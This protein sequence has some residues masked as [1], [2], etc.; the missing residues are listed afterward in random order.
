[1]TLILS[2]LRR[3]W[4]ELGLLAALLLA[5]WLGVGPVRLAAV[6]LA[7]GVLLFGIR[8]RRWAELGLLAALLLAT[9]LP[10]AI[11]G[12]GTRAFLL[13][14]AAVVLAGGVLTFAI[15]RR[16]WDVVRAG[17]VLVV[18]LAGTVIA[19]L[20]VDLGPWLRDMAEREA[21][22]QIER[23]LH[24]E[25]LG[26]H[27]ASGGF[28]VENLRIDGKNPG[29]RPFFT[30]KQIFVDLPWW[31][32]IRSRRLLLE[33]I[34]MSGWDMLVEKRGDWNNFI[35]VPRGPKRKPGEKGPF[36]TVLT[37]VHA[38]RGNFTYID[39]GS[40]TTTAANLDIVVDHS[41][42]R[43]LGRGSASAGRVQVKTYLP[44]RMDVRFTFE[45]KG[46]NVDFDRIELHTD[47]SHSVLTGRVEL[48]RWPE[49]TYQVRSRVDL[50]RSR[51]VFFAAEKWRSR[52]E[53]AFAGTYHLPQ[54][55]DF[56]LKGE[57]KA[58]MAWVNQ[59]AFP[60]LRGTIVWRPRSLD[61]LEATSR[62]CDGKT[63]FRYRLAPISTP[64][65]SIARFDARYEG[66][67]LA[68]FGDVLALKGIRMEGRAAGRNVM[69]WPLGGWAK[70][71]GEGEVNVTPPPGVVLLG[72]EPADAEQAIHEESRPYGPE[73][74]LA[75][76]PRP[77]PMGGRFV[78]RLEPDW[79]RVG[80][81][82]LSTERTHVSFEG[83][84]AYGQRSR[85]P[86]HARSA[87]WQESDRLLAS[88]ITAFG[89][90]TGV[91][92]V[93]GHG[94][95]SGVML[96]SVRSPRVEGRFDGSA[97]RAWD[98]VWG[99]GRGDIVVEN[100][101]V[102]VTGGRITEGESEI[103]AE[104]R[105][106]LGYPRR[107]GGEEIDAR[108]SIKNRELHDLRHAFELDDYPIEGKVSGEFH[109][110]G[111]YV[112]PYGYGRMTIADG[113]AWDE[114]F[115]SATA[116]LR[117]DGTGVHLGPA[118]MRKS[119]G[120]V[121]GA[122]HV[123][124]EGRYLFDADGR[125]IP[126]E[127]VALMKYESA[128]LSGVL[129]FKASGNGTF[130]SPRYEVTGRI[131]DLFV[132]DEGIGQVNGLLNVRERMLTLKV[133]ASSPRLT[134]TGVGSVEIND[135]MDADLTFR[136]SGTSLDPYLRVFE[137]RLSPFTRAVAGGTVR[138]VGQLYNPERL[139]AEARVED[140]DLTLFDYKLR[141]AG[142]IRIAFD[143]NTVLIDPKETLRLEGEDTKLEVTGILDDQ[144]HAID[145]AQDRIAVK[146]TGDSNLAVLQGFF[147]DINSSGRAELAGTIQGSIAKPVFSGSATITDGRLRYAGMPHSIQAIN[148]RIGFSADGITME[149]VTAQVANGQVR[150]GGGI[151]LSGYAPDRLTLTASGQNM[152]LRYPEGMRSLVDADLDL[153]GTFAAPTLRGT[154][155]VKDAVWR[156]RIEISPGLI[157][158]AS[159]LSLGGVPSA[160]PAGSLP[161]RFD[162]QVVAR[163]AL[164]I[165]NN[166]VQ[167]VASGDLGVRGDYER[168]VILGSV[169][170]ERGEVLLEGKRYLVT[171]GRV[172]FLNPTRIEPIIDI[173]AETRVRAPGQTYTVDLRLN[174]TMKR[175]D[176]Q[177]S[178]EPPLPTVEILT[179]LFGGE[180]ANTQD[181]E[182]RDLQRTQLQG[183]LGVSRLE[184]ALVGAF[185]GN[186]T[187]AVEQ[188]FRLDTVQLTPS[189]FDPYKS[190]DPTAR[191]TVGK[192]ISNRVYLTLAR[193]LNRADQLVLLEFDQ[194]DRLS[195]VFSR[196]EDDTYALDVRVR[197]VF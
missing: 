130:L 175:L 173:A 79:L 98:V 114:P 81:S 34:E 38:G 186:V 60:D 39:Y 156:K 134:V 65:P 31:E 71:R 146:A 80:P 148:G 113:S 88:I 46:G 55:G 123:L 120:L 196:N 78:Y 18:I 155:V 137:P 162:I 129:S 111:R 57:F 19:T 14:S 35:H 138:V 64:D 150:F 193:S 21:S 190:I 119:T 122:A 176:S 180:P 145:V 3:R 189:L 182:L 100:G 25:R 195:W 131:D 184:Q 76:T 61:V 32:V 154:V 44:M 11:V 149:D 47:N 90:A 82:F 69:E 109:L 141:N 15:R 16:M 161:L 7:A 29:D 13:R 157:E 22:K 58:P 52:G 85:F 83:E 106:S 140:L 5:A 143:R 168:P 117:F 110:F 48:G 40:W 89:S 158:L 126:V 95:V 92:P 192:R 67:D 28:L 8:R 75:Q 2:F 70:L 1:M 178:S 116:P 115:D 51:E 102:D 33:S 56:E 72:V 45:V 159:G 179:L 183:S 108:V 174:G 53:A 27:L 26:I 169:D 139:F 49:Q 10:A 107:D 50:W 87:D 142:P 172:E 24:I 30:A 97:L 118:E 63:T 185:S 164:R 54:K 187:R 86:F 62:F 166:L 197:H 194:N 68:R 151:S 163:S 6:A 103:T 94:E 170:V 135:T 124:W 42:G 9:W 127:S 165:D 12:P 160:A 144:G 121:N 188:A 101:Y 152:D 20:V 43:Y 36:S 59:F 132:K 136:V 125:G 147:R 181:A 96:G 4:P 133:E 105:F 37:Y 73:P 91:V 191:L 41:T 66:V 99:R 112:G 93:G 104:G 74:F 23:P 153:V 84:T 171:H 17:I 177:L 167:L 128:P 77:T